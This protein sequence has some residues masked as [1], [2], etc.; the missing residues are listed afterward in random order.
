MGRFYIFCERIDSLR[1]LEDYLEKI[2]NGVEVEISSH[3]IDRIRE[4][5]ISIEDIIR[6]FSKFTEKYGT[7]LAHDKKRNV[8]GVIQNVFTHLNMPIN[9]DNKGTPSPKDDVITL[10]TVMKKQGFVPNS[11]SDKQFKV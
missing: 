1:E 4:R 3:F 6:T 2:T 11:P 7:K 8:A 10:I 9:W 5:G